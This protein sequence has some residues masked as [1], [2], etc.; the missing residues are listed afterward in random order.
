[1]LGPCGS[2]CR[3]TAG[4]QTER[5]GSK[6]P[7]SLHRSPPQCGFRGSSEQGNRGVYVAFEAAGS[8][9]Q[10]AEILCLGGRLPRTVIDE[11]LMTRRLDGSM[12][13]PDGWRG[14]Q[15]VSPSG[16]LSC[17]PGSLN[18]QDMSESRIALSQSTWSIRSGGFALRHEKRMHQFKC[19]QEA[20][21]GSR[22]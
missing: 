18:R 7:D 1:M 21:G 4:W 6:P 2:A 15:H 3:R 8:E 19:T 12:R 17:Q 14:S 5:G 20:I 13:W 11:G 10:R 16:V 22:N 9:N